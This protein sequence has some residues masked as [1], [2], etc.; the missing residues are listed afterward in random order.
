[1][2]LCVQPLASRAIDFSGEHVFPPL[3]RSALPVGA[4]QPMPSRL[5][6]TKPHPAPPT[7]AREEAVGAAWDFVKAD[8]PRG[9]SV[10]GYGLGGRKHNRRRYGTAH[11]R[12]T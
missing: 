3:S 8:G 1:M 10:T 2:T 7:R 9:R 11:I 12:P 5:R 4:R 6:K